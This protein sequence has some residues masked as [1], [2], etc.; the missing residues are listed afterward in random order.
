[1]DTREI[2][3]LTHGFNVDFFIEETPFQRI[4]FDKLPKNTDRLLIA[5]RKGAESGLD[6]LLKKSE[7]HEI[8]IG[9]WPVLPGNGY[10]VSSW[11]TEELKDVS[12][13]FT[14]EYNLKWILLDIE[15]HTNGE[16]VMPKRYISREGKLI[17]KRNLELV[18]ESIH[19]SG[20]KVISTRFINPPIVNT[21]YGI[22]LP[23]DNSDEFN[24]MLYNSRL[25][26]ILGSIGLEK[27]VDYFTE[28]LIDY[29]NKLYRE[30]DKDFSVSFGQIYKGIYLK[31]IF[32]RLLYDAPSLKRDL[33]IARKHH[34][35]RVV[36]FSADAFF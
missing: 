29:F 13:H 17:S 28:K 22:G 21:L 2:E 7:S 25:R 9:L 24:I 15:A 11:N 14:G 34:L 3:Y 12:Q 26:K 23:P 5:V 4:D 10:H 30:H 16:S 27:A 20:T 19:E 18:V 6:E 31:S 33:D 32:K 35:D 8:E 1:M 36:I